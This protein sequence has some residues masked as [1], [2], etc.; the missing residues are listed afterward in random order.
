MSAVGMD[1]IKV[2]ENPTAVSIG[3]FDGVHVGHR[4][5]LAVLKSRAEH[6]GV[7]A[8]VLT[9][10]RHPG[11]L[12]APQHAP[13]YIDTLELKLALL[14]EAGADE[15]VVVRFDKDVA[16]LTPEDFTDRIL[17]DKLKASDIVVGS[18]FRFGRKREGDVEQL[19]R[20]GE[21]KSFSVVSVEPTVLH[22]S[23][24]SSTRVRNAIGRGDVEA[25]ADLLGR[26]FTLIGKVVH[27]L[28]IGRQLGYPTANMQVGER[29]LVPPDGV[30]AVRVLVNGKPFP[31]VC[32]I[33]MRPTFGETDRAIEVLIDGFDA[34]IYDA[35]IEASFYRKL[36]GQVKFE[37]T[38]SLKLQI[39]KDLEEARGIISSRKPG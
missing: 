25:A 16:D 15:V 37:N 28:G 20:L 5:L 35:E 17:R 39:G 29:Q 27:G 6:A 30:Y 31:G 9:F 23:P 18:N 26:P 24:V 2:F 3:M 22:G 14:K 10:D 8:I 1:D 7:P 34:D 12:L 33:G 21:T 32:S 38:D 36:R 13:L 11:E 19:R 4:S